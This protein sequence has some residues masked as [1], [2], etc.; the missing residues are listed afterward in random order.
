MPDDHTTATTAVKVAAQVMPRG[1]HET[2][3][4]TATGLSLPR[5]WA[6]VHRAIDD[7]AVIAEVPVECRMLRERRE[8]LR[9]ARGAR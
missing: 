6:L 7:L 8:R 2:A 1:A 5:A 3:M 4:T 9:G